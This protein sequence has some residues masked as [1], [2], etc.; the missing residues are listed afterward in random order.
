MKMLTVIDIKHCH[1]KI[2]T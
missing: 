1:Y 2:T